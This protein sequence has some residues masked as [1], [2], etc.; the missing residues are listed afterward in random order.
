[1]SS[2][3]RCVLAA[4]MSLY[5]RCFLVPIITRDARIRVLVGLLP[6]VPNIL[7]LHVEISLV[8]NLLGT[9][10]PQRH[11]WSS[12]RRV[13]MNIILQII[14][15]SVKNKIYITRH[16]RRVKIN[17]KKIIDKD[18]RPRYITMPAAE[19]KL[20]KNPPHKTCY[21][22]L[23]SP[24]TTRNVEILKTASLHPT[25]IKANYYAK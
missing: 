15:V 17:L 18:G 19:K 12:L 3:F 6:H 10:K 21:L 16:C 5:R 2:V 7:L 8:P 1:M 11:Q 13:L 23:P 14:A 25:N 4:S 20:K 22:R 9:A 24:P